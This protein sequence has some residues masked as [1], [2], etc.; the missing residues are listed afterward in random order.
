MAP[1]PTYEHFCVN[2]VNAGGNLIRLSLKDSC[3]V[4]LEEIA[5]AIE[6]HHPAVMY[7]VS[8]NNPVGTQWTEDQV[9]SLATRYPK[10]LF[11]LDE[12]YHEFASIDPKTKA[13]VTCA[14]LA[15]EMTNVVVTR[16]FSKAFC[17]A[18]VRCGYL[19]C[20]PNLIEQ[21]RVR[22]NPKSVNSLA[23]VFPRFFLGS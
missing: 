23:Q 8:P 10:T 9:R 20:H 18:S 6:K 13:P 11:I 1:V 16:T 14:R 12:A 4:D 15:G 17:L 22:Y 2:A 3:V 19:I 21:L 5:N 7:L